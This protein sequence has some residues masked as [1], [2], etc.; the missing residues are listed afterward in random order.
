M[1]FRI[2]NLSAWQHHKNVWA[3]LRDG[4]LI[5][6]KDGSR[7][8]PHGANADH[9]LCYRGQDLS[10]RGAIVGRRLVSLLIWLG[11]V[12]A[13]QHYEAQRRAES[14]RREGSENHEIKTQ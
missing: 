7:R 4:S 1:R 11:A 2:L 10:G 5:G 13:S 12:H 3:P 6:C 14:K 8:R 9:D